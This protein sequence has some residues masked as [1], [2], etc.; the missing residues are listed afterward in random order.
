MK[1]FNLFAVIISASIISL[2]VMLPSAVSTAEDPKLR[3]AVVDLQPKGISKVVSVA[4][5]DLM[6]SNM[7]DTGRFVVVE[8]S[9][10]DAIFKE[11]ALQQTGCTDSACAVEMGKMLS[12]NKV[13]VGEINKLGTDIV[14]TVRMVDVEKGVAEFSTNEKAKNIEEIDKA[15]K[16][17]VDKL[18]LRITG[19]RSLAGETG[20]SDYYLR[21]IIPGWGQMYAGKTTKGAIF[22]GGFALTGGVLAYSYFDYKDKKKSYDNLGPKEPKSTFDSRYD[23]YKQSYN[24]ML[25][26]GGLLGIIYL[27]NWADILFI[28]DSPGVIISGI[29]IGGGH[30]AF[31]VY[32]SGMFSNEQNSGYNADEMNVTLRYG[33]RF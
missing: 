28:T 16:T 12:A 10:M 29:P 20:A 25:Y 21:G 32:N 26:A 9:Q 33:I 24:I 5:T 13:L 31:D 17:L 22:M 23:E 11:Q 7:V 2:C 8:R 19:K 3:L 27:A 14:I 4:V 1:G 6:R 18:T 15:V 30:L